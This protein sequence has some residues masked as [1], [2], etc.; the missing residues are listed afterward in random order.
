MITKN[1]K[2]TIEYDGTHYCGWQIQ[3]DEPTVQGVIKK[4]LESIVKNNNINVIGSGRTD[5]GVHA[6]GQVFNVEIE[7]NMNEY[8]IMKAMNSKLPKDIRVILSD[9]VDDGFNARFSA[10]NREYIYKIKKEESA[11]DYKYYWNY[12][13]DYNVNVLKECAEIVL[14]QRNF[15]NFCRLSPDIKNYNCT[16]NYSKWNI[17]D[18]ILSYRVNANRFL[19]HMVRM[20]VGTMLDVSRGNISKEFFL[21]LFD[22]STDK[23]KVLTA[24]SRGLYLLKVK[25]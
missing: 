8:Q 11:F 21:T 16:I 5:S 1:F 19:H 24:P 4:S 25:Y 7:T 13:Y 17:C 2:I 15:Y 18:N 23:N 14:K 10:L 12:P 3:K 20:L 6:L 22:D 9:I